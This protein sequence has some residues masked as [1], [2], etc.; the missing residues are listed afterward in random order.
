MSLP[1]QVEQPMREAPDTGTFTAM[2]LPVSTFIDAHIAARRTGQ[3]STRSATYRLRCFARATGDPTPDQI[4]PERI[5]QW[6]ATLA[7]RSISTRR[8]HYSTVRCFL[9]WLRVRDLLAGDPLASIVPPRE[10]RRSPAT[11][12]PDETA[13]LWATAGPD[14]RMRA[15]LALMWGLGLR[16]IDVANLDV[17]DLDWHQGLVTIH[18]KASNVD[19]LPLP[20]STVEHLLRYLDAHPAAAGP[21]IRDSRYHRAGVS[22]QWLSKLL[23]DLATDAGVKRGR[24][25][26]RGAHALRRT[27]GTELLE[28]GAHIRQVQA[29]LRHRSLATTESY[30][31]RS[32]AAELR[33]L[34]DGRRA[35]T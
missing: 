27:F 22:P 24:W 16:C 6:W 26:G 35:T 21:L 4:N 5:E 15:V 34:V 14:L 2:P 3:T 30:L 12:T 13:A 33:H 1:A 28:G 29:L 8:S 23:A 7:D 32:D 19:V 31:R 9:G 20:S 18:G 11:L 25:D 10:P 17:G